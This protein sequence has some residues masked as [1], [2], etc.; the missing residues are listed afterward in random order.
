MSEADG[1]RSGRRSNPLINRDMGLLWAAQGFSF[2]GDQIFDTT[3]V[4]WIGAVLA[5][6]QPWAPLAVAGVFIAI[7]IPTLA[8]GPLAGVFVDRSDKRRMLMATDVA[9]AILIAGLLGSTGI[10]GGFHPPLQVQLG[11]IYAVVFLTTAAAQFF[12]PARMALIRDVVPEAERPR[13]ISLSQ[14]NS[15]VSSIIGPPLAVPVLFLLGIQW[16]LI[17]DAL[18]FAVSFALIALVKALPAARRADSSQ[19]PSF[20]RELGEGFRFAT[21][22]PVARALIVSIFIVMLGAGALN[23]L[24]IF[25]MIHN[26]NASPNLYGFLAAG[27]GIG[28]LAG[29]ILAGSA[30]GRVGLHRVFWMSLLAIGLLLLVYARMTTFIGA[31]LVLFLAGFPQAA[32]NVVAAPILLAA[33]PRALIGRVF[34]LV[35]PTTAIAGIISTAGSGYL[36]TSVL[37]GFHTQV[38]GVQIGTY[39]TIFSLAG[40]LVLSGGVY[41]ML[42]FRRAA[43]PQPLESRAP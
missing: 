31:V 40:L 34:A 33:V 36:A 15:S 23:A 13:A 16:A 38:G 27:M 30:A 43:A 19:A 1:K 17:A 18:S 20:F 10:V 22:N 6:G 21:T 26:L 37:S 24:D 29:A 25:F 14:V 28:V 41:A 42:A 7:A 12:G 32:V 8:I 11:S 4:V 3:L 35:N 5:H 39:D 9:R 2:L